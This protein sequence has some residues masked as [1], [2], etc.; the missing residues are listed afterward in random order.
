MSRLQ[1]LLFV[2]D[3]IEPHKMGGRPPVI[4]VGDLAESDLDAAMLAYLE[5]HIM[6]AMESGWPLHPNT[7]A[8]R[9]ELIAVKRGAAAK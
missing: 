2:A 8:A 7:I 3:K 5:Y 4:R 6:I 1:K 9:N